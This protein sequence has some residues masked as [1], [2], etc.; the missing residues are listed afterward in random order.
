MMSKWAR[1]RLKSPASRLFTQPFIQGADNKKSKL[2]VTGLCAGN[3]PVTGEFPAQRASNVENV[4]I[5]WRHHDIGGSQ[6]QRT[7]LLTKISQTCIGIRTWISNCIHIKHWGVISRPFSNLNGILIIKS[8]LNFRHRWVIIFQI[9]LMWLT[10]HSLVGQNIAFP[11]MWE[12]V[13][14][15]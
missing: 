11:M 2:R 12:A 9:H 15:L 4:S 1:W 14:S 10:M 6:C 13:T 5:W 8:Q 3:S 7:D